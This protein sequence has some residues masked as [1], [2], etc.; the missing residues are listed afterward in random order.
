MLTQV[1]ATNDSFGDLL[2]PL[3]DA[4]N[5]YS[6]KGIDGLGPVKATLTTTT[7]AQ[8]DGAKLNNAR[9]EPRNITMTLGLETD[10]KTN[11]V[12]Q[13]RR[14]LYQWFSPKA[15][16]IFGLYEDGEPFGTTQ[17]VVESCEPNMFTSDPAVDISL[18][19]MDPD[20]Y[21]DII[22][23]AG[24]TTNTPTTTEIIYAGS[25]DAGIEFS[26]TF[27]GSATSLI[28]YNTRPDR[29]IQ[30]LDFEG[31]F[32]AGD[33]LTVN[34]TEGQRSAVLTT[35]GLPKSVLS[36]MR[37]GPNWIALQPGSNL[38][39]AYYTGVPTAWTIQYA[40]KYGGF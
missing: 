9:R 1:S 33:I 27:A 18:L 29:Q 20:F 26:M 3:F 31:A 32:S 7:L 25:A 36:Y 16:L 35:A 5:G 11:S 28:L 13:L 40:T 39:R 8:L 12:S 21:G 30:V 4:S 15:E 23:V 19:C 22:P 38:F 24:M 10:W 6:V 34:T 37:T 2:L 14:Q 17:A